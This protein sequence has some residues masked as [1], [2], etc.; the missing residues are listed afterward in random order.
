M[1]ALELR[2]TAQRALNQIKKTDRGFVRASIPGVVMAARQDATSVIVFRRKGDV[3]GMEV[4]PGSRP[5]C[6][7]GVQRFDLPADLQRQAG[8]LLDAL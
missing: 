3:V 6:K 2:V 5:R 8:E 1:S 7:G 4:W